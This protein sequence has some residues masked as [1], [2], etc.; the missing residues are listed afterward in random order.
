GRVF[1]DD[2][3]ALAQAFAEH[4]AFSLDNAQLYAQVE[5]QLRQLEATQQQLLQAGKLA[6]VGQLATGVAHA[7]NQPLATLMGQTE[8]IKRR[9]TDP[10][11]AERVTKIADSALRASQI[12][13]KLQT[14]VK[15]GVEEMGPVDLAAIIRAV[16]S[17]RAEAQRRQGMELV[18]EVPDAV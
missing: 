16:L 3:I 1:T 14:F 5:G 11:L 9:I 2:E 12:V 17:R 7:G 6:A 10:A 8:M 15:P 13:R 18:R 4:A